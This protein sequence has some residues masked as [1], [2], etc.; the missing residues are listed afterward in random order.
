MN[1]KEK[2]IP[3]ILAVLILFIAIFA[4][5]Y[6]NKFKTSFTSKANTDCSPINI[7]ITNLTHQSADLSFLTSQGCLVNLSINNQLVLDSFQSVN[8]NQKTKIHYFQVDGLKQSST[9]QYTLIANGKEIENSQ[10]IIETLDQL[11]QP[12][13]DSNLAWGKILLPS[14]EPAS[15]AIIY[16]NIPGATLMS[17]FVTSEGNWNIP[18]SVSYNNQKNS[19]FIP[20]ENIEEEIIVLSQDGQTMLLTSNTSSNNPVP[21]IIIGQG[22]LSKENKTSSLGNFPAIQTKQE[23]EKEFSIINPQDG[24]FLSTQQPEFFGTAPKG[25]VLKIKLHSKQEF[26]SQIESDSN[27]NWR[28]SPDRSLSPGQHNIT[29]NFFNPKTGLEESIT[30]KF[31][32]LAAQDN[33]GFTASSSAQPSNTPI[34]PTSVPTQIPTSIPSPSST[35]KPSLTPTRKPSSTPTIT[36]RTAKPST[37][38]QVP[39]TGSILPTVLPLIFSIPAIIIALILI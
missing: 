34:P 12:I 16:L 3:T 31:I 17:S 7:Q 14:L 36:I 5:V 29:L 2:K 27:G 25:V 13:P 37:D 11:N 28:W 35:P 10:L 22:F 20:P 18:L 24:E 9:Y 23:V 39:T 21:D 15:I 26:N 4:T 38:S 8:Q 30:K 32:V 19:W 33:P 6:L 1:N